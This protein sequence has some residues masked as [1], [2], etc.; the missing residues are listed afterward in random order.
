MDAQAV[1]AAL[2]DRARKYVSLDTPEDADL[3]DMAID[4]RL[5]SSTRATA[6]SA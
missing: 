6:A 4:I 3:G 2:R 1:I 5:S